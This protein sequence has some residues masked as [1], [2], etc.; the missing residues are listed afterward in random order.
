MKLKIGGKLAAAFALI[1]A[2]AV[3]IGGLGIFQI[4][5]VIS[6]DNYLFERMAKPLANLITMAEDFE[7]I[8]VNVR[9]YAMAD[10]EKSWTAA[11][12]AIDRL[13]V[14]IAAAEQPFKATIVTDNGRA[15]FA[16][17]KKSFADYLSVT[18][19]IISLTK[20]GKRAEATALMNG[21]AS[22]VAAALQASV[23]K[24][25]QAKVDL[26]KQTADDNSATGAR[27]T[28]AM[29]L[30]IV[31][32][33]LLALVIA[34]ILT[35]SISK[36]I[37]RVVV[38]TE[39][40][41]KGDLTRVVHEDMLRRSDEMG[42]LAQA[43]KEMQDSLKRIAGGI[44]SATGQVSTGSMQISTTAQEMSQGATE[45]AASTEEVSSSIEEMAATIK[46]N[47]D[48]ALAT[49]SLAVK[50]AKDAE[51]GGKAV[52]ESVVAMNL[53][54]DKIG[55][56]EEIA[57][58]TNLLALNAAIEAARA[59]EAGKGFAVVASEVRKLAERSQNASAEITK[60]SK[61]TMETVRRAGEVIQAI[62]PDIKKTASLV[63]E[64]ASA[65]RE[66]DSGI[67][68]INKAMVQ[69]DTV[70]QQNASA[71]EELASMS[72]ELSGQ[73]E[74]LASAVAFFKVSEATGE[75]IEPTA[76]G[77]G[78]PP[79]SSSKVAPVPPRAEREPVAR[80]AQ[81][82]GLAMVSNSRNGDTDFE[83]F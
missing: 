3:L 82:R 5:N 81:P 6:A 16:D 48:N 38:F 21:R 13:E 49:E 28:L 65:S 72:E 39:A 17:Y 10:D 35:R 27:A 56:I 15:L 64:I 46:Q 73:S 25:V 59:G 32:T 19:E 37:R 58:Q 14:E 42:E 12:A 76:K 77:A 24:L 66:Q 75:G 71:S 83:E 40:M 22:E 34:I 43:F 33:A 41:A 31:I 7:L 11:A 8:R 50:T 26:S 9:A 68:Q 61:D 1:V 78:S 29:A 47:S 45:Q 44:Q 51:E 74:Q 2:F 69:L 52:E 54:A 55:I 79:K 18:G 57:R 20:A 70:V 23:D 30:I 62:V 36:P 63:Q 60:L 80:P 53:I 67:E 4:R